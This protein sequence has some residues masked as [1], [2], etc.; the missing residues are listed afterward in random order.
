MRSTV[1]SLMLGALAAAVLYHSVHTAH[2]CSC[3]TFASERLYLSILQLEQI[4]GEDAD[5]A[6][7][8]ARLSGELTL[9]GSGDGTIDLHI[10]ADTS[11]TRLT[12]LMSE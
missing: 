2:A 1:F 10:E 9:D 3:L 12:F 6:A 8:E 4:D 5:L 7:E 11:S